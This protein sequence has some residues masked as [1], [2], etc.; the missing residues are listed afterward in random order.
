MWLWGGGQAEELDKQLPGGMAQ[1]VATARSLLESAQRGINP[2]AGCVPAVP[3]GEKLRVGTPEFTRMETL[4]AEEIGF[5]GFV[6]VAGGL[7]ER[8]GYPGIKVA[9][10]LY[11]AERDI[12]YLE[13]YLSHISTMQRQHGK[14]RQ[15]PV[16]IMTSDDTHLLTIQLLQKHHYFGMPESQITI[17]KQNK[18]PAMLDVSAKFAGKDGAIDTKPHGH[19]DVH[20]LLHQ[21]GCV[22]AWSAAGNKWVVFFQDTNGPIFRAVT[23]VVGVSKALG[24]SVNSVCVPRTPGEAVG[25]I[26]RLNRP[27]GSQYTI[28]VEYNQLDPLLRST[29]QYATGMHPH[30]Y[31]LKRASLMRGAEQP[32]SRI[33]LLVDMLRGWSNM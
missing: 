6:L 3:T 21:H 15:I 33:Y 17:M 7:G 18:V 4:G 10:P 28:N 19:G 27:D 13:L 30:T 14:G 16:A 12:C 24:L 26:C 1:Y 22:D 23:A 5:C 9:L 32:S 20:T 2:L 31:L 11:I 29:T 8:L 25:G